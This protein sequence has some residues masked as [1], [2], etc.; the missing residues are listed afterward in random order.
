M[1]RTSWALLL[2]AFILTRWLSIETYD[3][4]HR[5]YYNEMVHYQFTIAEAA[6]KGH[7]FSRDPLLRKQVV[8]ASED[9]KRNIPIE[10]YKNFPGSG[11]YETFPAMDLPGY[12]YLIYYTSK[13]FGGGLTSRYAFAIQ[14]LC[15]FLGISLFILSIGMLFPKL[16]GLPLWS[17]LTYIIAYPFILNISAQPMRDIFS[18]FIYGLSL[19]GVSLILSRGLQKKPLA[20]LISILCFCSILLWVRPSAYYFFALLSCGILLFFQMPL[21][22]KLITAL[23]VTLI[24][25]MLFGQPVKQF[26]LKHYGTENTK[27]LGWGIWV[28]LGSVKD[29][30]WG[31]IYGDRD[32]LKWG[33][34]KLNDPS[35]ELG[36][37]KLNEV[38]LD[39]SLEVISKHP[40]LYFRGAWERIK[41]LFTAPLSLDPTYTLAWFRSSGLSF[42]EYVAKHPVDT[43]HRLIKLYGNLFFFV[44]LG[45]LFW[46]LRTLPRSEK[47]ALLLLVSPFVYHTL[48]FVFYVS[49]RRH[50]TQGAW[51]LVFPV[52]YLL[53][54]LWQKKTA[55]S[56]RD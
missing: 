53:W 12:G 45:A 49:E 15:E 7:F 52:A 47:V 54:T 35:L 24:P 19:F 42:T 6:S 11:E 18:V 44:S 8:K 17:G 26:N 41:L 39:Y 56:H 28:A 9:Q 50:F 23:L 30:P 40:S 20:V 21:K 1:K 38:A 25:W 22:K 34:E 14:L 55:L 46:M 5:D 4:I 16:P 27:F 29:N 43:L 51:V 37:I 13:L 33:R 2:G 10:E 3:K 31:F 48:Q 36:S 32:L